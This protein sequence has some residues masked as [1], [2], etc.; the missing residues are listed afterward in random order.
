ME[1][2]KREM[3]EMEEIQKVNRFPCWKATRD[4]VRGDKSG[5]F[6]P[7]SVDRNDIIT[8]WHMVLFSCVKKSTDC[9][10]PK[11]FNS[12]DRNIYRKKK[13]GKVTLALCPR[14]V[15]TRHS[16]IH[17]FPT[18][19][20]PVVSSEVRCALFE[21]KLLKDLLFHNKSPVAQNRPA[22]HLKH[23]WTIYE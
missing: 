19:Q 10:K 23:K 7:I 14:S 9:S 20:Q 6:A 4:A 11:H 16:E 18:K 12:Q 22:G 5:Y 15:D 13:M 1:R 2:G 17:P 21:S 3:I 8:T